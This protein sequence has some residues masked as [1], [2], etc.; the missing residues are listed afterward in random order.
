MWS[1]LISNISSSTI[2]I[3]LTRLGAHHHRGLPTT[4]RDHSTP[5]SSYL[6]PSAHGH[7]AIATLSIATSPLAPIVTTLSAHTYICPW[8]RPRS[9]TMSCLLPPRRRLSPQ[10][11]CPESLPALSNWRP[12]DNHG[13]L[14]MAKDG[15]S[16]TLHNKM[17]K[18]L[19]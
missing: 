11:L 18:H 9:G 4:I 10:Q 12:T 8:R 3:N 19:A 17:S 6:L 16:G 14:I 15:Y 13:R 1:R 5:P 7:S 2:I